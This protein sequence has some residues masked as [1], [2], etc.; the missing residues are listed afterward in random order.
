M[1]KKTK[2]ENESDGEGDSLIVK[3]DFNNGKIV[4]YWIML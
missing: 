2:I 4:Y 1:I 3:D